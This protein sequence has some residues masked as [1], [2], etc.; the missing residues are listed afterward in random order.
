MPMIAFLVSCSSGMRWILSKSR[1]DRVVP[2]LLGDVP[3]LSQVFQRVVKPSGL[4]AHDVL[5]ETTGAARPAAAAGCVRS[6]FR[7][8]AASGFGRSSPAAVVVA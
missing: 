3:L 5:P 2:G 1:D 8:F 6:W 4:S 7:R